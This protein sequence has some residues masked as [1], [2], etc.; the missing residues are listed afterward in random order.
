MHIRRVALILGF[1]NMQRRTK[2]GATMRR[3]AAARIARK[4]DL[5]PSIVYTPVSGLAGGA[6]GRTGATWQDPPGPPWGWRSPWG[7][8]GAGTHV[9][10][11]WGVVSRAGTTCPSEHPPG[12]YMGVHRTLGSR[13][14]STSGL[15]GGLDD[16]F[17][18]FFGVMLT[19]YYR[20]WHVRTISLGSP[21]NPAACPVLLDVDW[22]QRRD[23]AF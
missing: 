18:F 19:N 9:W 20:R 10:Q 5:V 17:F 15:R 16:T 21:V 6:A 1:N 14:S 13:Q 22:G 4:D 23:L 11:E 7:L 2:L 8:V 3:Y 12:T